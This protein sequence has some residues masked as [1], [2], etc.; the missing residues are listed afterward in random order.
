MA[1]N[2]VLK[3]FTL[4]TEAFLSVLLLAPL[5]LGAIVFASPEPV[6]GFNGLAWSALIFGYYI[7][8]ITLFGILALLIENNQSLR[9]IVDLLEAE[10]DDLT[11]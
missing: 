1:L 6:L 11:S 5:L 4:L 3:T 2:F 8:V 9:R 10:D 7:S